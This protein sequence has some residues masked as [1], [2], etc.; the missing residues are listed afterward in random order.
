MRVVDAEDAAEAIDLGENDG[1]DKLGMAFLGGPDD[2]IEG[3]SEDEVALE[4]K[5]ARRGV[6]GTGPDFGGATT[7]IRRNDGQTRKLPCGGHVH[8]RESAAREGEGRK[9]FP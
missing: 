7:G 6:I 2:E 8:S 9:L 4:G 3:G 5:L 1:L